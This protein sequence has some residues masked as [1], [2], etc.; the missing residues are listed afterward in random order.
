MNNISPRVTQLVT[1]K[2]GK[3]FP[4]Y[5][6]PTTSDKVVPA[7]QCHYINLDNAIERR[8]TLEANFARCA[9]Q[10]WELKRFTALDEAIVKKNQVPGKRNWREKACFLSHRSVIERQPDDGRPFMVLEDDVQ[11]G[12]ASLEI[13]EGILAENHNAQWDLLFTDVSVQ[14]IEAMM[15]L[16]GNR[17]QLMEKRMVV[18]VDLATIF[19][20]GATAY[21]VNGRAK[22]KLLSYLKAGIPVDTEYDIHLY[23]GIAA[24][25][26]KAAVLFPFVTTLS[27]HSTKSQ[28]QSANT[29]TANMARDIF[30]RMMWL[31]SSAESYS[32][33]LAMIEKRLQ[34]TLYHNVGILAGAQ[35]FED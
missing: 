30:R 23:K 10:G 29:S 1:L 34:G 8:A 13:I 4:E 24:G 35:Y 25:K 17:K 14:Q 21:V 9:R 15:M 31:E 16:A 12:M 19:F 26:L 27:E 7:M 20:V 18:P 3:F 28:I 6:I 5:Q 33:D 32:A 2:T 11:F 22:P